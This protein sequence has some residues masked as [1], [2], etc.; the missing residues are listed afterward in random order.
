M[1][2]RVKIFGMCLAIAIIGL[3]LGNALTGHGIKGNRNLNPEVLATGSNS[4]SGTGT[5]LWPGE[6]ITGTTGTG[7]D[8]EEVKYKITIPLVS[9]VSGD[10]YQNGAYTCYDTTEIR[11]VECTEGGDSSCIPGTLTE[12]STVCYKPD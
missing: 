12:V 4:N 7:T 2:K 6:G 1:N 11:R 8:S 9:R 5:S 10:C 3:S